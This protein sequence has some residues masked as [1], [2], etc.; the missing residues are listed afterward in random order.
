MHAV[1]HQS[2]CYYQFEQLQDVRHGIFTRLGG[3]SQAPWDTLNIGGTVGDDLVAVRRNHELMYQALG[4]SADCIV[5]TWQ[6]HG[7]DV[8]IAQKPVTG[9][10]WLAQADGL[11]TDQAGLGLLMRFADCVP[12]LFYDPHRRAVGIAHAGWRGTV[13]GIAA[14]VIKA[15]QSAYGCRPS[16]IIVGIGPSICGRCFQV[17]EEVVNALADYFGDTE[18][19]VRR[20]PDDGS[21]YVDLWAA[22]ERDLRRVGVQHI[23]VT[24]LCTYQH[25][26]QFYSHRAEKGQT[27]RFGAVIAL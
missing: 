6:V 7:A 11:I 4:L 23:S 21:A 2:L 14:N 19:L 16:D 25:T 1:Y 5:T 15:M 17:G 18:G 12:L 27:G 26:N 22:N 8:V 24:H 13:R 20:N 9:R 3:V 10:R